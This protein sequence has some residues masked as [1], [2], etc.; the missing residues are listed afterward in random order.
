MVLLVDAVCVIIS[1]LDSTNIRFCRDQSTRHRKP[2]KEEDEK[3]LND[4][5]LA[6][7]GNDQPSVF[8][9]SPRC[10]F[11]VLDMSAGVMISQ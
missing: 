11:S 8:E 3:L 6:A 2:E 7:D 4:G 5:V 10:Q 1:W 9:E